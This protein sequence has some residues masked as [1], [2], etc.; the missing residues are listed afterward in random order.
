MSLCPF[1][2]EQ[3]QENATQPSPFDDEQQVKVA[4]RHA[5]RV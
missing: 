5:M 4:P 1:H 3:L 2:L